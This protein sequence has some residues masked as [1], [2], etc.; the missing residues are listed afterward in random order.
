MHLL[1]RTRGWEVNS[2]ELCEDTDVEQMFHLC[3]RIPSNPCPETLLPLMK[4]C[5]HNNT[6]Y[7]NHMDL[8]FQL[9]ILRL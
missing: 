3:P 9:F 2:L 8:W 1:C 6:E 4:L 5:Y 7:I